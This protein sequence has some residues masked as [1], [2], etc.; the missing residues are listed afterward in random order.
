VFIT[1]ALTGIS[2]EP[3][4]KNSSAK[5]ASAISASAYGSRLMI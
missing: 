4:I 5:V 2:A 3:V 1:S